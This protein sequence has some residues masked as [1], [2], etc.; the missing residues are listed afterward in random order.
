MRPLLLGVF[1]LGAC[2]GARRSEPVDREYDNP[3]SAAREAFDTGDLEEAAEL[4]ERALR[5]AR[6]RDEAALISDAAYNLSV[7]LMGLRRYDRALD[8]VREARAAYARVDGHDIDAA[9]LQMRLHYADD[10][11]DAALRLADW[12]GGRDASPAQH[13]QAQLVRGEI[14]CDRKDRPRADAALAAAGGAPVAAV[15]RAGEAALLEARRAH[16]AG[17]LHEWDDARA[18]AAGAFELEAGFRREAG[19]FGDMADALARA[20]GLHPDAPRASDL[21]YRAARCYW[22][23]GDTERAAALLTD[24]AARA[25]ADLAPRIAALQEEMRQP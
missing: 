3:A 1:L 4:F 22:A 10:D 17:R 5:R 18:A 25:D 9:V 16:L 12:I 14:A 7:C 20:G 24:A 6:V 19:F 2:G 11:A 13:A 21:L 23:R 8:L 15:A